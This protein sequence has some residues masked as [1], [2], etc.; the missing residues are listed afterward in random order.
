[1]S[2]T[3][4]SFIHGADTPFA[5]S[6][7][8]LIAPFTMETVGVITD[9]S[10]AAI[11]QAVRSAQAAFVA[12]RFDGAGV[13]A[14]WLTRCADAIA[15]H[16]DDIT[17][18]LVTDIGKPRRVARFEIQR[19]IAFIRLCAAQI[20]TLEC[21]SPTLEA[22]A[23]GVDHIGYVS[24][25]AYGVIAAITPFN[26]PVNLLVQKVMPALAAGNAVV[27]KPH[28]AGSRAALRLAELCVSAGLPAGLFNVVTG[29]RAPAAALVGH[30]LVRAVTFTGGCVAADALVRAAGSKKFVAEL[31]SNA[32]NIVLADADLADAAV[33]IAGAAFEASGQQC[34][35]AQR[36]IVEKRA[37]DAFLD[38]F[39]S[40]GAA[41][42]VGDPDDN[43]TDI[44][45]MVSQAAADRVEALLNATIARGARYALAPTRERCVISPA[46]VVSDDRTVPLWLDEVF[47]PA[48][49]VHAADDPA[50]ALELAN[51]SPFGL[52]GALFTSNL[53]QA[54][55]FARSF[56]VGSLWINEPSRFRLDMVPFGGT[57]QSG[58]GREGV[59]YAIEEMS[60]LKFTGMRIRAST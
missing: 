57:K 27:V 43:A 1:M 41:L 52:Q 46:V 22:S 14:D 47:G 55:T 58:Y 5:G 34:I 48:V 24:R 26:A 15:A 29:D 20:V 53:D 21:A 6:P 4:N 25:V 60:Q 19:S 31:G 11:D 36:V 44:G 13:R 17:Q 37:F 28:P 12:H 51:D 7:I 10:E 3:F 39:V 8:P 9:V 2:Q 35:S 50:H 32:A 18:L 23:A 38:R 33:R 45:P 40:A 56:D 49:I 30:P 16:V 59:R 42:K 54:L